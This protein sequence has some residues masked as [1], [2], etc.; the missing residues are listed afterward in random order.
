[1]F[2]AQEEFEVDMICTE[3]FIRVECCS[4]DGLVA[5]LRTCIPTISEHDA[6]LYLLKSNARLCKAIAM[7]EQEGHDTSNWDFDTYKA[8]ADAAWHPEPDA[9]VEFA[10]ESLPVVRSAVK[11]LLQARRTLSSNEIL[12]LSRLLSLSKS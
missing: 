10:M 3:T 12:C 8:A 5:F 1:M 7:A 11:S 2:P 4:L 9:H 6:M